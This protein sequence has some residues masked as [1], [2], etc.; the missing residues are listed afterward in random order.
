MK[1]MNWQ[2]RL[3]LV[4]AAGMYCSS[5]QTLQAGYVTFDDI[6][7]SGEGPGDPAE[8]YGDP[9]IIGNT[10]RFDGPNFF[11]AS[12]VDGEFDL[13]AFFTDGRLSFDVTADSGSWITEFSLYE[14]GRRTFFD[15]GSPGTDFTSVFV[16]ASGTIEITAIDGF[17]LDPEDYIDIDLGFQDEWDMVNDPGVL[18]PWDGT[19]SVD[20]ETELEGVGLYKGVDYEYG[21][22]RFEYFMNNQLIARSE[23]GTFAFIDKKLIE[24]DIDADM[25]P[26]PI[27]PEPGTLALALIGVCGVAGNRRRID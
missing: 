22:T 23:E 19:A 25:L 11:S 2:L 16:A 10:L 9:D 15:V 13:E 21:V 1:W 4:F 27:I 18:V 12:S 17:D 5:M 3:I 8:P 6:S 20:F 26:D 14:E 7:Q 24:I